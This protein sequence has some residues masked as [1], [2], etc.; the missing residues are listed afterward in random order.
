MSKS[1]TKG[2]KDATTGKPETGSETKSK[3]PSTSAGS[4]AKP[5]DMSTK[6]LAAAA[7]SPSYFSSVSSPAYRAGWGSVFTSG[8]KKKA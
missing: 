1:T 5:A 8:R 4:T 7:N 6:D 2:A 3:S